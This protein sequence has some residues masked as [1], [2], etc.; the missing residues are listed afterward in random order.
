[1]P[2]D[3]IHIITLTTPSRRFE[4]PSGL[5]KM[6]DA[7]GA[8]G[9]SYPGSSEPQGSTTGTVLGRG[10]C[11]LQGKSGQSPEEEADREEKS[12]PVLYLLRRG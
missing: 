7:T 8:E 10:S 1:M 12:K 9:R 3:P 11:V 5:K 2:V 6:R 4:K